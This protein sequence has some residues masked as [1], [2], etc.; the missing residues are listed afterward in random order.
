MI[1][2]LLRIRTGM[3][4]RIAIIGA[5]NVG[6]SIAYAVTLRKIAAEVLLVDIDTPRCEAQVRLPHVIVCI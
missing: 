3:P 5:G 1:R 4:Q 2:H 6:A